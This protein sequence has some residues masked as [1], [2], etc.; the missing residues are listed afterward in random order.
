MNKE[1]MEEL[2]DKILEDEEFLIELHKTWF[3]ANF[4]DQ[5]CLFYDGE[6]YWLH[7]LPSNTWYQV[8]PEELIGCVRTPGWNNIDTSIY[9][10][11][12]GIYNEE[13]EKWEWDPQF[14]E[15]YPEYLRN[16]PNP[17][18]S[19]IINASIE[20]GEWGDFLEQLVDELV[21]VEDE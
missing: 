11:Y 14:I 18:W 5:L 20:E 12:V 16:F 13:E 2:K 17:S 7:V 8:E 10:E 19:D 1:K 21:T 3:W 15:F 9:E 4:N 6:R